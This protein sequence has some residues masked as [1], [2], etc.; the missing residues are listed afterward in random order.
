MLNTAGLARANRDFVV[1]SLDV[2]IA[3]TIMNLPCHQTPLGQFYL[4]GDPIPMPNQTKPPRENVRADANDRG[5]NETTIQTFQRILADYDCQFQ[6]YLP[7][8][9]TGRI[10]YIHFD[11]PPFSD[12]SNKDTSAVRPQHRQASPMEPL[13]L[14]VVDHIRRLACE[15]ATN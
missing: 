8:N 7:Q 9:D 14:P 13:F 15:A 5:L 4:Q 12:C 10:Q 6:R 2:V 11:T 1:A 3:C